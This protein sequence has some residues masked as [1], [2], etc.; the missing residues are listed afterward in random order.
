MNNEFPMIFPEDPE[1]SDATLEKDGIIRLGTPLAKML[2]F[3]KEDF[4]PT[5]Y[6]WKKDDVI[7]LSLITVTKPNTGT[8]SRLLSSIWNNNYKIQVPCPFHHMKQI[9]IKKG[10][11]QLD[12]EIWEK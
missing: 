4:D 6:L 10:F 3:N 11:K 8:L 12:E 2:D 5:S 7:I 9:L 1:E